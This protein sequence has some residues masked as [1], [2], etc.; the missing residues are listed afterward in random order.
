MRSLCFVITGLSTGGAEN[1]LFKLLMCIDRRRFSPT[2]ISLTE[3]GE[4]GIRIEGLGVPVHALGMSAGFGNFVKFVR[5]IRLFR[6][7]QPDLVHTWMYHADFIGGLAARLAGIKS[8]AW[9]IRNS[10][11]SAARNKLSTVLIIKLCASLSAW[12]PRRI[13]CCSERASMTHVEAGYCSSKMECIP[14]GF[15]LSSFHPDSLSRDSFREELG[16]SMST[17]LIG[18]IARDDPQKNHFGFVDAAKIVNR[19]VPQAH[20]VLEGKGIDSTNQQLNKYIELAGLVSRF[21]LLGR[22]DDIPRVMSALDVLASSSH[23]EAFPN[24]LGEAMACGVP[25]VVTD[26]GDCREIVGSCGFVVPPGDMTGV[27]QCLVKVLEM[28]AQDRSCVGGNARVRVQ[29]RYEI[30]NI[31]RSYQDFY[32]RLLNEAC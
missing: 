10:D 20:F 28:S 26:V 14:N 16:V 31:A 3:K 17:P 5:L 21:H 32:I 9:C 4:L 18:L 30:S 8:I 24:V 2:V 23:G 25:C 29:E 19:L 13:L 7:L 11:I 27:A 22:R 1:M 15:D 6:Q 12:L